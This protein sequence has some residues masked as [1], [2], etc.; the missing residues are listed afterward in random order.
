MIILSA[1]RRLTGREL[2]GLNRSETQ[3][4]EQLEL[5][6]IDALQSLLMIMLDT[7]TQVRDVDLV[8]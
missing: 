1:I 3:L 4:Q 5:V 2:L 8:K 6:E 7:D